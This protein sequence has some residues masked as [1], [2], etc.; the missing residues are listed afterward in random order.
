MEREFKKWAMD[1]KVMEKY[2]KLG[3]A[4]I[5]KRT[6][7]KGIAKKIISKLGWQGKAVVAGLT[8]YDIVKGLSDADKES[9]ST[10]AK[11]QKRGG[12]WVKGKCVLKK[13]AKTMPSTVSKR[14]TPR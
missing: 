13:P 12:K 9:V 8:A 14:P 10:S 2:R 3:K 5:A 1:P 4:S 11:C 6:A 7:K